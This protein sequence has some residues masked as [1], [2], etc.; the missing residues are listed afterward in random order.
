MKPRDEDYTTLGYILI[1]AIIVAIC[2]A[3]VLFGRTGWGIGLLVFGA[4]LAWIF[5]RGVKRR[6]D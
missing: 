4:F 1:L 3:G 2:G 6:M 5:V